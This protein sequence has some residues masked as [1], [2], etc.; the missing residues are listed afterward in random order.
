MCEGL[1]LHPH[2][3]WVSGSYRAYTFVDANTWIEFYIHKLWSWL[4]YSANMSVW[5]RRNYRR[6]IWKNV[7]D[8]LPS[9]AD[10]PR[11]HVCLHAILQNIC[12]W[13]C[14]DNLSDAYKCSTRKIRPW[15]GSQNEILPPPSFC[16]SSRLDYVDG[17]RVETTGG[18]VIK[19]S[20]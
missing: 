4:P 2:I 19:G 5:F 10:L 17:P 11:T 1:V 13:S 16:F 20:Y 14:Q 7:R 18:T 9:W 8:D 15:Q 3:L 12:L 6:A